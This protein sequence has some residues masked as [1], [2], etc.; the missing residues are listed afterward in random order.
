MSGVLTDYES[1]YVLAVDIGSSSVKAGLFDALARSVVG[2]EA[3]IAHTQIVAS[4]G[5]S[6]E[7]ADDIRIATEQAIDSVL[8][9][10][11]ALAGEVIGV[12]FD[13]MSSTVLG[14]DSSG[15]A[16]TPVYTYADTRSGED[17]DRLKEE[18]NV[19]IIYDRTGVMQHT[20][21]LPGRIRWM[22]RTQPEL[23]ER[24]D[25]YVDVSTY[26]F[27]KWFGRRDVKASYC[28]SSWSGLLNRH[29]LEWDH[30]LL[31]RLGIDRSNLPELA[32][33]SD[34]ESGLAPEFAKRWPALAEL[35]FML[36]VGD[37]AAVNVGTG[38]V[39]GTKVA[40]TVGTTGAMRVLSEGPAPDVPTG[41]WAYRLGSERTLLGG[42]F[43]EGGNVVQWALENLKLPAIED[44]NS[45]LQKTAPAAHGIHVLPFIAGERATGWSTA[46]TGVLEGIKISTTPIEILQAML[47]SVAYRFA[48]VADLLLP[49]VK[50]GYQMIASGG[51]IQ[52][53]PW[54][55]QTMSDVLGVPV[56]VSA[57]EQDTSRGTAIL[58]L[59]ALGVWDSLDSHKAHIAETYEPNHDRADIYAT[60]RE[61]QSELYSHLL[62]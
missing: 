19:P 41:L 34:A 17:V 26:I 50:S 36:A 3:T 32:P 29:E 30:G 52:N 51:A 61:R 49:G 35:P 25:R 10:A 21:Y 1:P 20:S 54:W 31:G 56:G 43:S 62:G 8:E 45:E 14:V 4:D 40:L 57:E 28:V 59:N 39:D 9:K 48:M 7:S 23:A 22:R 60:A 37:G 46:A 27:T 15:N 13:C 2:I 16:I 42:S 11:G 55:L 44:L 33:W 18:L 24:V 6:E 12:G 47:E 5:T 58:A 38:C 53:S